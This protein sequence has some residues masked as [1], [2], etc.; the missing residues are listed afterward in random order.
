MIERKYFYFVKCSGCKELFEDNYENTVFETKK[1]LKDFLKIAE[2]KIE[3]KIKEKEEKVICPDC[4]KKLEG[5]D[6]D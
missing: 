1:E 3:S 2:W 4:A 6:G 5:K